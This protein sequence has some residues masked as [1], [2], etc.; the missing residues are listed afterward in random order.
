MARY[1][2]LSRGV[3][4]VAAFVLGL[5]VASPAWAAVNVKPT[6]AVFTVGPGSHEVTFELVPPL[7]H[8]L[9]TV[10]I[11]FGD[12]AHVTL[13]P[14]QST[15]K[16]GYMAPSPRIF[17]GQGSGRRR[18]TSAERSQPLHWCDNNRGQGG[19]SVSHR[20]RSRLDGGDASSQ[21]RRGRYEDSDRHSRAPRW[22]PAMPA[23]GMSAD[24]RR[25]ESGDDGTRHLGDLQG[26]RGPIRASLQGCD[27]LRR[28]KAGS[29]GVRRYGDDG[30]PYL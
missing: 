15:T 22:P 26:E 23:A 8:Q 13:K 20:R 9:C 14:G 29:H 5:L 12:G 4:V 10:T 11:D 19:E 27:C 25:G 6:P 17:P 3:G 28:R 21:R 18:H 7:P 24:R 30:N 16:H 2:S 1:S